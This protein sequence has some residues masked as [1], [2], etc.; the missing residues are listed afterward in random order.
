VDHTGVILIDKLKNSIQ[1]AKTYTYSSLQYL[2]LEELQLQSSVDIFID[3]PGVF[4][5]SKSVDEGHDIYWAAESEELF[6]TTLLDM[7][8][9]LSQLPIDGTKRIYIGF[10]PPD[11]VPAMESLEF[12][13]VSK[14]ID[15]WN[16]DISKHVSS[17]EESSIIRTAKPK[18]YLQ[19]SMITKACENLSR[20]FHGEE[21]DFIQEWDESD[22]SCILVAELN[23]T[24][25]GVCLLNI[26]GIESQKGP[27]LWLRELAVDPKYHNQGIG[28]ELAA[29]GLR[30]GSNNGAKRSF[31]AADSE[32]H[33]AI[34]IYNK[35]G[36]KNKD[37]KGQ[38]NMALDQGIEMVEVH[39]AVEKQNICNDILR[40]LPEWFGI[41]SAIVKYSNEVADQLFI[42]ARENGNNIG[43]I[44]VKKHYDKSAEIYVMGIVTSHHRRGIGKRLISI[45]KERLGEQQ[46]KYL[47]VKTLSESAQSKPYDQS[48]SFYISQGFEPLEEF[49]TLWDE[50]NPCLY[51]IMTIS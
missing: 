14:F 29:E 39:E 16:E 11:F 17:G 24:I 48:R 38:I 33:N 49:K 8:R 45:V 13:V 2:D 25:I 51:M 50:G 35:L 21:L 15:F 34:K 3:E 18:D 47:T 7:K 40:E 44:S 22:H 5:L 37:G 9:K 23:K 46:V 12:K 27:V 36:Y 6:M 26:Y 1:R 42:V 31:L 4:M 28:Y 20:G 32:N 10:I 43:F 41:E 30:W 19:V